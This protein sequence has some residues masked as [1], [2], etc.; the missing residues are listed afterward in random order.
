MVCIIKC[1]QESLHYTVYLFENLSKCHT[2]LQNKSLKIKAL[3]KELLHLKMHKCK[4]TNCAKL[5][6]SSKV[7]C[8]VYCEYLSQ[9]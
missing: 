6:F 4:Q 7:V 1:R 9:Y 8:S 2:Q 5:V 3:I